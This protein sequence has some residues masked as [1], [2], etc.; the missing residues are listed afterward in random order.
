MGLLAKAIQSNQALQAYYKS[1]SDG[2]VNRYP[3]RDGATWV[4][5]RFLAPT[6]FVLG[7]VVCEQAK[8]NTPIARFQLCTRSSVNTWVLDKHHNS[9]AHKA[10][11][12]SSGN[13]AFIGAPSHAQFTSVLRKPCEADP[14]IGGKKRGVMVWCLAE[15]KRDMERE[16]V[17]NAANTL[18]SQDGCK[19]KLLVRVS[20]SSHELDNIRF[21]V[22]YV[23]IDGTDSFAIR[24]ATQKAIERWA[25]PRFRIP[26]YG[27]RWNAHTRP[28]VDKDAKQALCESIMGIATDAA[29]DEFRAMRL[30]SGAAKSD[31]VNEALLPNV[32]L[33]GKDPTHA[34][35]RFLK[36]WQHEPYLNDIF[37]MLVWGPD[38][39]A[40]LIENSPDISRRFA[41]RVQAME[42]DTIA[43]KRIKNMKF[44][45]PRFNSAQAPLS[46]STL[47]IDAIIALAV[48]LSAVRS[49]EPSRICQQFLFNI[50]E[51]KLVQAA[52]MADAG[53][54]SIQVT[55]LRG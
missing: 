41:Q 40:K 45:K 32:I 54:E 34:S 55:R 19:G 13:D 7:C 11:L 39:M 43:G 25:T 9:K 23:D 22:N 21:T 3:L 53:D 27:S 47:Y 48:E 31:F 28:A 8:T 6:V 46:R 50:D 36:V 38:S 29:S 16:F 26:A 20:V 4:Q 12:A 15:A 49:G 1:R 42:S 10:A 17:K 52:M 44:V 35:G 37:D 5:G 24:D 51:E 2:F 33:H 18:I 14:D 30:A